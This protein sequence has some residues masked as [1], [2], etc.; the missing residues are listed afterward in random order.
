MQTRNQPPAA[1]RNMHLNSI[2]CAAALLLVTGL[3]NEIS[4][5]MRVWAS[6]FEVGL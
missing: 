3:W 5:W 4:V 2:V 6:G 1:H